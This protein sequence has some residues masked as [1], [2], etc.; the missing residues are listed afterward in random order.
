[1]EL[2]ISPFF[3]LSKEYPGK[4]NFEQNTSFTYDLMKSRHRLT[5]TRHV[6]PFVF[7]A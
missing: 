3:L 1:M 5:E 4:K 2:F 7:F 6:I